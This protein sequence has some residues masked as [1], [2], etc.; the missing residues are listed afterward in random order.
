G[1]TFRYAAMII[2]AQVVLAMLL[3]LGMN[4]MTRGRNSVRAVLFLPGLFSIA[5]TAILWQW[6]Y[7]QE[8]GLFTYLLRK[9]NIA[10]IPWLSNTS[11]AMPSIVI[12]TLSWTVVG[13]AAVLLTGLQ[14]IPREI[15]EADRSDGATPWQGCWSIT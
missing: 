14:E 5:V 8:F 6:F 9:I 3:A 10:P 12:M 13:S 2:P 11:L 7:N 15:I 4:A 1:A